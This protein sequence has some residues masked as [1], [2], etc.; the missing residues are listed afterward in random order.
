MQSSILQQVKSLCF[1]THHCYVLL[2]VN[3]S[4][5]IIRAYFLAANRESSSLLAPVHTILPEEKIK[6]VVRGSLILI[7]TAANRF[8]LYSAFR[9]WR[10]IFFK[11]NLQ[12]RL[13]VET[14]FLKLKKISLYFTAREEEEEEESTVYSTIQLGIMTLSTKYLYHERIIAKIFHCVMTDLAYAW[15]NGLRIV[16]TF[17]NL[18]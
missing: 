3:P 4:F 10:A 11:S 1:N 14:I 6:A 2:T 17:F 13:T 7:M 18:F 15:L 12:L 16:F 9:A 5:W 8:G